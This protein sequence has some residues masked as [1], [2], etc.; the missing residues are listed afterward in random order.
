MS[1]KSSGWRGS[2]PTLSVS[3]APNNHGDQEN[4]TVLNFGA[5]SRIEKYTVALKD[6]KKGKTYQQE[7]AEAEFARLK[8]GTV[9]NAVINNLGSIKKLEPK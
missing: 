2:S 3:S 5:G 9:C 8:P 4:D 1:Q 7:V 6:N